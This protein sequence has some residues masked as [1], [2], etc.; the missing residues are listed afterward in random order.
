VPVE[1]YVAAGR[2]NFEVSPA[3]NVF[4]E[5][6]F[7]RTK[8]DTV[9]EPF[10]LSS[11]LI[12]PATLGQIAIESRVNGILYRNPY[13]PNAILQRCVGHRWRWPA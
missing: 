4:V 8:A 2:A 10:P 7:A 11:D 5:G 12:N 3:F 1:R 13:V 9:I 6:N